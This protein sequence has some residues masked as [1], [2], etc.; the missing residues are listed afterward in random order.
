M[1]KLIGIVGALIT[2]VGVFFELFIPSMGWWQVNSMVTGNTWSTFLSLTGVLSNTANS[3][4]KT[5]SESSQL[6]II[7][8]FAIIGG[9]ALLI[10]SFSGKSVIG[11]LGCLLIFV[12]LIWFVALLPSI[13]ELQNMLGNPSNYA[14]GSG[15]VTIFGWTAASSNW[16]LSTGFWLTLSG[17]VIGLLGSIAHSSK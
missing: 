13:S 7:L 6:I 9:F 2:L 12:G 1:N 14:F 17:G 8:V 5:V 15:N 3:N 11:L 4:T 10:G 16:F